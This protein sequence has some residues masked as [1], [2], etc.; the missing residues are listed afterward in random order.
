M[1][2][3]C[4]VLYRVL[5]LEFLEMKAEFCF[6]GWSHLLQSYIESATALPDTYI[7]LTIPPPLADQMK[8]KQNHCRTG[9]ECECEF[10][11][12]R[13]GLPLVCGVM[14]SVSS[15]KRVVQAP[16]TLRWL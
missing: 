9:E 10:F 12:L 2:S 11:H 13:R 8:A 15:S 7:C 5:L 6:R 3:V 16:G 1:L 4:K 14:C